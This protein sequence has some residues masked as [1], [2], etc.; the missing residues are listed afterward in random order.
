MKTSKILKNFVPISTN[1]IM[2][3]PEDSSID[4]GEMVCRKK[5]KLD[6]LSYDEKV[7]RK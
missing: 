1:C 2:S 4:G 6:H 5:R 7:Q 3:D